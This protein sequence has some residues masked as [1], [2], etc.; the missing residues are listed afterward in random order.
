MGSTS[1]SKFSPDRITAPTK[2]ISVEE[3]KARREKGLCYYCEERFTPGHRCKKMQIY[4]IAEF[5]D[6]DKMEDAIEGLDRPP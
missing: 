1:N 3:M 6:M 4:S 5:E 2:K